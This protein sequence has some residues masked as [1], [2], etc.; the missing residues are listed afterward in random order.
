MKCKC[1]SYAINPHLHGRDNTN[2]DLC[3]VCYWRKR[4]NSLKAVEAITTEIGTII[5][6]IETDYR[7]NRTYERPEQEAIS[8]ALQKC[9]D[10]LRA[11]LGQDNENVEKNVE[12]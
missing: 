7:R 6:F 10:K 5:D 11:A 12:L 8:R 3:D 2:L 9:H 1:G 4:A